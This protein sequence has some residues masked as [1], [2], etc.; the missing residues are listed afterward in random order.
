MAPKIITD[1]IHRLQK[2]AIFPYQTL[3]PTL[4][5]IHK[6]AKDD[7]GAVSYLRSIEKAAKEYSAG[8]ISL[9]A[10]TPFEVVDK[11]EEASHKQNIHGIIIISDYGDMN[12]ILYDKIPMSLDIDSLSTVSLG[13]LLDNRSPIAY[14]G[15]PCTAVACMKL[16]ESINGDDDFSGKN[17]L[18]IG[19][20]VRVGRP[21]A[22]ILTQKNMTVTVAHTKTDIESLNQRWDYIVSAVGKPNIW[23]KDNPL[24][25]LEL[26]KT[27]VIDVG[28]NL[29]ENGKLCGDVDKRYVSDAVSGVGRVTTAVLFAKLFANT[30][31]YFMNSAGVYQLAAPIRGDV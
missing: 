8:V 12:R 31:Q 17:C 19:R 26:G 1:T 5:V 20:S 28:V 27:K 3:W 18:I 16:I 7:S 25:N 10:E 14:R 24:P 11:I 9:V 23:N 15:A 29:D 6:Q 13:K 2:D 4:A 30:A 22:E 21:L